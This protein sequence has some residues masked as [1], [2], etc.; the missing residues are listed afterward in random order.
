[1]R[2]CSRADSIRGER[3]GRLE[4][5]NSQES[6]RRSSSLAIRQRCHQRQAVA[7]ETPWRLAAWRIEQP[8]SIAFTNP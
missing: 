5:S 1:M 3:R 2:A 6:V 7:G 4:R 8:P